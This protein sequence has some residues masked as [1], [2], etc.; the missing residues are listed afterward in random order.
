MKSIFYY[1]DD[2]TRTEKV[3]LVVQQQ[4][5]GILSDSLE[6]NFK[7]MRIDDDSTVEP[8]YS[9]TLVNKAS[10]ITNRFHFPLNKQAFAMK[11]GC[12]Y[13]IQNKGISEGTNATDSIEL[14]ALDLDTKKIEEGRCKQWKIPA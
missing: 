2:T 7:V 12:L 10:K 3:Y 8:V 14:K 5:H 11:D 13:W 4:F 9:G 1:H 6:I